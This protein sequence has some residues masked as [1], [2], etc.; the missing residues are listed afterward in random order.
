M[1][2]DASLARRLGFRDAVVIGLGSMIG[3]GLFSAFAPAAAAAGPW[4]LV[5]LALAAIVAW[6]NASSTAQLAAQ[7]PRSGGAY[8]SGRERLGEWPGFLAGWSFVVGKTASCAAMALTVAAYAAPAGWE[9]PVAVAAVVALVAV[10][11]LGVTRTALATR[12]LLSIVLVVLVVAM[13]AA[14]ASGLA[15][16]TGAA[17]PFDAYGV[18]QSAGL[19]FFAF[20]GYARLATMGEEVRDPARTIPRAILGALVLAV[21]LYTVVGAGLLAA[22]GPERLA[23]STQPLVDAA[24]AWPWTAVP[25]RVGAAAASLG[26]LLALIAGI[27]RTS[28]AMARNGDLPRALA[29]I[30]PVRSVP[31][32]AE[33]AVGLIVVVLVLVADLR[34]AIGFSSFGVLLYY[35]VANVAALT[36]EAPHRRYPRPLAVVG[37]AGCLLLVATL[38]PASIAGGVAV[39]AAGAAYRAV[40]QS[41]ARPDGSATEPVRVAPRE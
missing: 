35:L 40:A 30:D 31:R 36:Q 34:S 15:S 10:N 33:I 2:A 25:I 7:Y 19:L 9:R 29:V 6:A 11:V 18:L 41:R 26:A 21:L 13:A 28:L 1:T 12:I 38:P 20:A 5:G 4:L 3:A 27:G 17:R 23:A 39:L 24:A 8:L 16:V 14:A 32:R 37:V 22:L